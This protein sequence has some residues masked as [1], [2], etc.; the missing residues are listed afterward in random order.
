MSTNECV[1]DSITA[2]V[3][4]ITI[5]SITLVIVLIIG[6]ITVKN[7]MKD[8]KMNCLLKW[9][10]YINLSSGCIIL[11]TQ[12]SFVSFCFIATDNIRDVM[13]F[14]MAIISFVCIPLQPLCILGTLLVR[15]HITFKDSIYKMSNM[16]RNTF[17]LLYI[18]V[19]LIHLATIIAAFIY[20][21]LPPHGVTLNGYFI[22]LMFWLLGSF[23]YLLLAIWTVYIFCN[24]L[25]KL[26]TSVVVSSQHKL[27]HI[28]SKYIF[29]FSI[30]TLTTLLQIILGGLGNYVVGNYID[31]TLPHETVHIAA[32][33][34]C[35]VNII[36]LYL[37]YSFASNIYDKYCFKM[38]CCCEK[39][40]TKMMGK[41]M[42]KSMS[43]IREK[44]YKIVHTY[45]NEDDEDS[46][47]E[48][49]GSHALDGDQN[50]ISTK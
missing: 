2:E 32:G 28:T 12:I 5:V 50:E 43:E 23:S 21:L 42:V 39:M 17:I 27:I 36:C 45:E 8:K 44:N 15:L 33:I 6:I 25:L 16:L 38:D 35:C 18:W 4:A 49:I 20:I 31:T 37:Q 10:F 13:V 40:I 7:L 46:G 14:F 11:I 48:K 41:T 9:L 30:A 1:S 19:V 26:A 29:L 47:K 3:I 34:D 24:N 22:F